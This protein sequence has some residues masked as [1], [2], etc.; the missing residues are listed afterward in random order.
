MS[1]AVLAVGSELPIVVI[2]DVTGMP[3]SM[4]SSGISVQVT[5]SYLPNRVLVS[6]EPTT[7]TV[8]VLTA[9]A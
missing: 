5:W 2:A 9:Q 1:V 4:L 6:V 8:S 3:T 7:G